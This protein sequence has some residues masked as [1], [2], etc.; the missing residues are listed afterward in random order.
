MQP[1]GKN[2]DIR[3]ALADSPLDR[4]LVART[5]AGLCAVAFGE[6]DEALRGELRTRYPEARLTEATN[7]LPDEIRF[8]LQS[9]QGEVEATPPELDLAGTEFERRVWAAMSGLRCGTTTA[10]GQFA[11]SL[12]LPTAHRAVGTA[13][14]KNPL[15]V[16]YPCHRLVAKG[17]HLHRYRWGLERKRWLLAREGV[18]TSAGPQGILPLAD[19]E[20]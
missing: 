9:L 11:N 13:V 3:Y 17:G 12:G 7:G 14:G 2:A 10:Y 6:D 20:R 1:K 16:L 8:V 15:A 5:D 4:M 18:G 19:E